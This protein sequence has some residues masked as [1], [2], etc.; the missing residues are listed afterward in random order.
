MIMASDDLFDAIS[1]P[2]RIEILKTLAKGPM[3]FAD[4]KR[5]FKIESSGQLDFHL[6]KMEILLTTN[7]MGEYE[8]NDR[9]FS[10]LR[11]VNIVSHHGWQRRSWF[12]NV[13]MY[14]ILTGTL[15]LWSIP[16]WWLVFIP[17]TGW[18]AFYTYWT[19]VKRKVRLRENGSS[20]KDA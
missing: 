5:K 2:L 13:I 8:L 7:T 9:G 12:V 6:K 14:L 20:I 15:L 11:A 10:A 17:Y 18:I 1:H 16:L 19:F 3:R 4:I